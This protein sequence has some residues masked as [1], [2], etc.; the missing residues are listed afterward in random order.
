M[1]KLVFLFK[2]YFIQPN[3]ITLIQLL[4]LGVI[5][6]QRDNYNLKVKIIIIVNI[7]L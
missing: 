1:Y 5:L 3:L 6:Y 2:I 7:I 4:I